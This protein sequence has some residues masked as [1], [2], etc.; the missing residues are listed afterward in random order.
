MLNA[1]RVAE[2]FKAPVLKH[3]RESLA[4]YSPI[5]S[6]QIFSMFLEFVVTRCDGESRRVS[7]WLGPM[8]GP[9][10]PP[11]VRRNSDSI[12]HPLEDER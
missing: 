4:P 3:G 5:P 12:S 10:V 6:R 11:R 8:L 1:G 9:T 7:A 2:R